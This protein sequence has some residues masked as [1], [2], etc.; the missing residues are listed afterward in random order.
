MAK[1]AKTSARSKGYRKT[2]QKK[3]FLTKKEIIALVAIVAAIALAIL[4]F[5]L[6]YD[7]GSLDVVDGVVQTEN[8][9]N[10]VIVQDHIGDETKY[11][12]VA[13]VG[14]LE[15]YTRERE[16]N[17]ANANLAT[18]VY[19]PED[20]TSPIDYIRISSGSYPPAELIARSVYNYAMNGRPVEAQGSL[21]LD[22]RDVAYLISSA[23]YIVAEDT[24]AD[25]TATD[26]TATDTT[27]TDTTA[28]D[29]T[30]ADDTAAETTAT[31]ATDRG[32]Y[33]RGRDRRGRD[34]H[35][36]EAA[37]DETAA[38]AET[39]EEE[40]E[41]ALER[42]DCQQALLR[43]C[44]FQAHRGLLRRHPHLRQRHHGD[45]RG[46]RGPCRLHRGPLPH[47]G[48][49]CSATSKR[50]CRPST[51]P[52]KRNKPPK[53]QRPVSLCEGRWGAFAETAR[54]RPRIRERG[55]AALLTKG[56]YACASLSRCA[57]SSMRPRSHQK[58][59]AQV[60]VAN[61]AR[62]DKGVG[63]V[64]RGNADVR[65]GQRACRSAQA[66]ARSSSSEGISS[67]M[68]RMISSPSGRG[69]CRAASGGRRGSFFAELPLR[70][71]YLIG[72]LAEDAAD[73]LG[74]HSL[75]KVAHVLFCARRGRA[76]PA[77]ARQAP[78][79][80]SIVPTPTCMPCRS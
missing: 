75:V 10:S 2:V 31:D 77:G 22:G 27:A 13:E 58:R 48:Q 72:G 45:S 29:A 59:A 52:W 23:E 64:L 34:R 1:K 74:P 39:A 47:G 8:F 65:G 56:A 37:A 32:R 28:T 73:V 61:V 55:R 6:L 62:A 5:N 25:E 9:D 70:A 20:E 42:Y 40:T 68:A 19:T 15:G 60:L 43:L 67:S 35:G 63:H 24:A 36:C 30:A 69:W 51:P 46:R 18:F 79:K 38:G 50:P 4:L 11:F 3:P 33:R 17:S 57:N 78:G 66:T 76:G 41:A 53:T 54:P 16:E 44:G 71:Q 12:K 80:V 49:S 7:D 21:E 26:A 14:E